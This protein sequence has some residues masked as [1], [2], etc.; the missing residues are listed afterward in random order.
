MIGP[1][2]F[3]GAVYYEELEQ[4]DV[5]YAF[6]EAIDLGFLAQVTVQKPEKPAPTGT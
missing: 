2:D 5:S 3:H 6:I 1:Q 4:E